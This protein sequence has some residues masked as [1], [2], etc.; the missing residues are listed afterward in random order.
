MARLRRF[1]ALAAALVVLLLLAGGIWWRLRADD[2]GGAAD[3]ESGDAPATSASSA[4]STDIAIPVEGAEVVR[5]TLVITVTAA[6]QAAPWGQAVLPAHLSGQLASLRV[7]ENAVVGAG[8]V[9]ATIDPTEYRMQLREA[10]SE[11]ERA[12]ASYRE[13]TLFDDRIEDA[14]TRAERDRIAR[15]KSGLDAAE[16][17]LE[18]ARLNLARTRVTA[19]FAGRIA[20]IEARPGEWVDAGAPLMRVVDLDPI[21]VEVQVLDSDVRWLREGGRAEIRFSAFAGEV[22][23]GRIASVNPM[24]DPELRTAKVTVLV[25]NPDGRVL[26][27]MYARVSLEARR[28]PDRILVPRSAIL[29]RDRR[30]MLFVYEGDS[31]GGLAK[32]RYVTPGLANDRLVEIVPGDGTEMVEPGEVVLTDGHYSLIHDARVRV[33]DD[34]GATEQGRPE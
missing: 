2:D 1:S 23:A 32:W 27:G 8:E 3:S 14:E 9:V 10:T 22:F 16:V 34:V 5:D 33:V 15:A 31:R 25:P 7:Q 12:R 11:L 30:T 17:R 29:E 13:L 19:P 21:R 26:P 20:S 18:R 28:F 4:F 24:V 6:A